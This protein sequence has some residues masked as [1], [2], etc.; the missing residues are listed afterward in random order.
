[1][2]DLDNIP[3]GADA[4]PGAAP[5]AAPASPASP[6]SADM[7]NARRMQAA[8]IAAASAR[9]PEE[10]E[11]AQM[12]LR[13]LLGV[14]APPAA[15]AV[16]DD[17]Y[18]DA[19]VA[20]LRERLLRRFEGDN[21]EARAA[22]LATHEE[23]GDYL[24]AK[25]APDLLKRAEA[26]A[27]KKAKKIV[28]DI[29]DGLGITPEDLRGAALVSRESQWSDAVRSLGDGS[30]AHIAAADKLMR[31]MSSVGETLDRETALAIAMR[32]AGGAPAKPAAPPAPERPAR[33]ALFSSAAE[34]GPSRKLAETARPASGA[35]MSTKD[36]LAA[37]QALQAAKKEGF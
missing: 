37:Y 2:S 35:P 33:S 12:G 36:I 20:A 7:A 31:Q 10:L 24:L 27:E 22:Q 16:E 15:E 6:S 9:T 23:L 26:L 8:V 21:D 19:N 11:A 13:Q 32:R 3:S 34:E 28:A 18:A 14:Q 5:T 25:R 30:R 29:F 1:M 4:Q 17:P